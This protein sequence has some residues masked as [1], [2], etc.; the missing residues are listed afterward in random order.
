VEGVPPHAFNRLLDV[1]GD[2]LP[3]FISV[4]ERDSPSTVD[5]IHLYIHEGQK[6]DLLLS[7]TNGLGATDSVEYD[8]LGNHDSATYVRKSPGSCVYPQYCVNEGVWVVSKLHRDTGGAVDGTPTL[9][10]TFRYE[11]ARSDVQGLG[12]LGFR[13]VTVTNQ[14]TQEQVS[15]SY[16]GSFNRVTIGGVSSYPEAFLPTQ[17]VHQWFVDAGSVL[18]QIQTETY[19]IGANGEVLLASSVTEEAETGAN[20]PVFDKTRRTLQRP[21][22][23]AQGNPLHE[24][25][26]LEQADARGADLRLMWLRTT[27]RTYD[28]DLTSWLLGLERTET[29]ELQTFGDGGEDIKRN[30]TWDYF[31]GTDLVL[32]EVREPNGSSDLKLTTTYDR[33]SRGLVTRV[34]REDVLGHKRITSIGYDPIVKHLPETISE[35][36]LTITQVHEPSL[37]AVTRLEGP[38]GAGTTVVYDTFGRKKKVTPDLAGATTL[39]YSLILGNVTLINYDTDGAPARSAEFDRLGRQRVSLVHRLD[40]NAFSE[41][42]TDYDAAGRLARVSQPVDALSG[43]PGLYY[44]TYHYD[45]ASR[46]FSVVYPSEGLDAN[47]TPK[48]SGDLLQ[49]YDWLSITDYHYDKVGDPTPQVVRTS[50]FDAAGRPTSTAYVDPGSGRQAS[51]SFLY[52]AA[53]LVKRVTDAAS[54]VVSM[55]YDAWGRRSH[56]VDPDTGTTQTIYNAFGEAVQDI[57]A[58]GTTIHGRDN[59]GRWTGDNGPDGVTILTWDLAPNGLGKPASALSPDAIATQLTYDSV[60]RLKTTT[61][62]VPGEASPLAIAQDRDQFGRLASITY[63]TSG[64]YSLSAVYGY[65]PTGYLA[66]VLRQEAGGA[67]APLWTA[68]GR[69]IDGQVLHEVYGDGTDAAQTETTRGYTFTGKLSSLLTRVTGASTA[70]QNASYGYDGLGRLTSRTGDTF[71]YDFFSRL[72]VWN[73]ASSAWTETYDYDDIG[74]LKHRSGA[75]AS[76]VEVD[77]TWGYGDPTSGGGPHALSSGPDG[78]YAYDDIGNQKAAPGRTADF[79]EFGLPKQVTANGIETTFQYDAGHSR[80]VKSNAQGSRTVSLG[81][82]YEKRVN[83]GQITYAFYVPA[84]GRVIAQLTVDAAGHRQIQELHAD[85][86]GSTVLVTDEGGT[87]ST[88]EFDPW[89]KKIAYDANNHP[90]GTNMSVPGLRIGFTGQD[91]DDDLG[92]VNMQ[93]RLYDPNQRRFISPDPF[94]P[95]LFD[96]QAHNRYA[97]VLNDPLNLID[98]SGFDGEAADGGDV[99]PKAEGAKPGM[100][101]CCLKHPGNSKGNGGGGQ[102]DSGAKGT[103]EKMFGRSA[104]VSHGKDGGKQGGDSDGREAKNQGNNKTGSGSGPPATN[105]SVQ[106]GPGSPTGNIGGSMDDPR[107]GSPTGSRE[108]N[109]APN[110]IENP[111]LNWFGKALHFG[112]PRLTINPNTKA[113]VEVLSVAL[114]IVGQVAGEALATE[115][116][117]EEVVAEVATPAAEAPPLVYCFPKGTEVE[118]PS[119]QV[120]IEEV[121]VGDEV[122]SYDLKEGRLVSRTVTDLVR[123]ATQH[124]YVIGIGNNVIKVTGAHRFWVQNEAR[125]VSARDLTAGMKLRHLD[126]TAVLV[127]SVDFEQ[128][129]QAEDTYNFEVEEDHNYFAGVAGCT[130]LAHNTDPSSIYFS[131]DPALIEA[132]DT[133]SHGPWAG[134]TLGEAVAEARALGALPKGLSLNASWVNDV[135]VTANNRTLWVAQ[136]AGLSNVSVGGLE[137][138]SVAKTV[139]T[140]LAE[141]GGPFCPP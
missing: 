30:Q 56:L 57:T 16:D 130:V 19:N 122:L 24:I 82:L 138:G 91:Q 40:A 114:P 29:T 87:P 139:M 3:D 26:T 8:Y 33:N 61:W 64:T 54:N 98:P 128:L 58:R 123:K 100:T 137:S 35:E 104:N 74:N 43:A 83:S 97:Y 94:V 46:L 85:N 59:L 92:L 106:P 112:M 13:H 48:P 67:T 134:R 36:G 15:T 20:Q 120:K 55:D 17:E 7:V 95:D 51:T 39:T 4:Q 68:D 103:F 81:G 12:W 42:T 11:D 118:T 47:G 115:E 65:S 34:T 5:K 1:N 110:G 107:Q 49:T 84:E 119:G 72:R 127:D 10:L 62:T 125:W 44:T 6:P 126:G 70:L 75:G 37:G 80:V 105:D 23:D 32:R 28:S 133:F 89:G 136:Q 66:S 9:D 18:E 140:H 141:S 111:E 93:G 69:A 79:W 50:V 27:D 131:R 132:S 22:Y 14:V 117:V 90:V 102:R 101:A 121:N 25:E 38:N 45:G 41:I 52:G 78:S 76:G 86:L 96:G 129:S 135:M 109:A 31:P 53:G 99:P 63:P 77:E 113:A 71:Q 108:P 2:G 88:L 73:H 60:S 21:S 124:W 116:I